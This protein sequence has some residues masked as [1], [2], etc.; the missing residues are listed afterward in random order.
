MILQSLQQQDFEFKKDVTLDLENKGFTDQ[1]MDALAPPP[2]ARHLLG[3]KGW[4]NDFWKRNRQ[5]PPGLQKLKSD[6]GYQTRPLLTDLLAVAQ[7]QKTE[8]DAV[9]KTRSANYN[10]YILQCGVYIAPSGGEKFE[11][12]KFKATYKH[13]DAA[14]YS[15]LPAPE[16]KTW[17]QVGGKADVGLDGKVEFGLSKIPLEQT[18]VDLKAKAELESKF[19]VSFH[20]ELKTPVVDAVGRSNAFC[21]WFMH[22][23]DQLRNDVV[24]YP[25]ISTPKSVK[26]FEV[27]FSAFFQVSHPDWKRSELYQKPPITVRVKA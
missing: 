4:W 1:E 22:R 8:L 26:G 24:F 11:A 5:A 17:F 18:K 6:F 16:T 25:V 9:V 20:Y 12:L 13:K 15:L 3:V 27:E 7:V 23:G 19:I 10:F 14:T 21:Q 2:D